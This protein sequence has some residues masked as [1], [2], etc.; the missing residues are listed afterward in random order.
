VLAAMVL[1]AIAACGGGSGTVRLDKNGIPIGPISLEWMEGQ[2]LAHLY[3]PG[4]KSFYLLG[5]GSDE[6]PG[7][8]PAYAGAILTSRS[9]GAQI[10]QWYFR[11][12]SK[13]GWHFVT[14]NGCSSVQLDCPQ[15]D[16]TGHGI[17]EGFLIAIDS[18]TELPFVIGHAPPHAC[19]VFEMS[20][21]VFPREALRS[22]G[23]GCPS[24][25]ATS[26]G[27]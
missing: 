5:A 10:Y 21:E 17:S 11:E 15:F 13:L 7:C 27:G 22:P 2:P 12:L 3:Y 25:A 14:D 20:F 6:K 4:A 9:T 23:P 19:T 26:A 18:P 1:V 24:A 16:H 8:A